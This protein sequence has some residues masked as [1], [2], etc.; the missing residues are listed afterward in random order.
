MQSAVL[1]TSSESPVIVPSLAQQP[2]FRSSG[3]LIRRVSTIHEQ[4]EADYLVRRMYVWRGY[5]TVNP[6]AEYHASKRVTLAAWQDDDLVAT[7]TL[8]LDGE[9]GLLSEL[10]YPEEI[11]TLR[12]NQ[13][14]LCEYSRLAVDPAFSSP[15]LLENFFRFAY[16][17]ARSQLH[18]SD[19]VVEI[20]PRHARYY[21]RE[22]G[23]TEL[24]PR[25]VCPRVDAPAMLLHR[26]LRNPLPDE[27]A[28]A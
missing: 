19:A 7:L 10:L 12:I 15:A 23:F 11:S 17:F 14:R 6:S 25:K 5:R 27:L 28:V 1:H 26:D 3:L 18:C 16:N 24:G 13:G 9:T 2:V 8:N 22:L 4:R 20:N 21:R